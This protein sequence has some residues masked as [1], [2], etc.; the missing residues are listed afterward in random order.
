MD[1][2]EVVFVLDFVVLVDCV[3]VALPEGELGELVP[4]LCCTTR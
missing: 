1:L 3:L 4:T 2:A